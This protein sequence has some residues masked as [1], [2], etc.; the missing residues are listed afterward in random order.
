MLVDRS[1]PKPIQVA[2]AVVETRS[3]GTIHHFRVPD[4]RYRP[5]VFP[6]R[7]SICLIA[8]HYSD[9]RR[10]LFHAAGGWDP[11]GSLC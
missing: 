6:R 10:W 5:T 4:G 3:N 7:K 11:A 9:I 2:A 1:A 8:A